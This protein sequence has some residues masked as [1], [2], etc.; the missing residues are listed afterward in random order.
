MAN[1]VVV[2]L[3]ESEISCSICL[4]LFIDPR[5]LPCMHSFCCKCLTE[6][7]KKSEP[8]PIYI[9]PLCRTEYPTRSFD[10][11]NI[12]V[13]YFLTDII[14]RVNR[15]DVTAS[16][17]SVICSTDDCVHPSV[18]YCT[19]GCDNLCADCMRHHSKSKGTRSHIVLDLERMTSMG[20]I[21]LGEVTPAYCKAHPNYIIDQYCVDCDLAACDTCLLR[22]HRKHNLVDIKRQVEK[23]KKQLENIIQQTSSIIEIIDQEIEDSERNDKKSISDIKNTKKQINK[24]IDGIIE[25]LNQRRKQIFKDLNKI[26]QQKEKAVMTVYNDQ[27][28]NKTAVASLRSYTKNVLHHGRDYDRVQQV[29]GLQSRMESMN[30]TMITSFTWS[31][32]D[33]RQTLSQDEM[34]VATISA[35]TDNL[36]ARDAKTCGMGEETMARSLNDNVVAKISMRT[37]DIVTGLVVMDQTVLVVHYNKS[38]IQA[39][40]LKSPH[41]SQTVSVK[42]LANPRDVVRFPPGRPQLVISDSANGKLVWI[43][44]EQH[45]DVWEITSQRSLKVNY[46]PCGLGIRDNQLLVCDD[47]G[48]I[49]AISTSRVETGSIDMRKKGIR[50]WKAV[51]QLT[52]P[53]FIIKDYDNQVVLVDEKGKLQRIYCGQQGFKYG[54]IVC[55]GHSIYVTDYNNSRVDELDDKGH[56]VKQLIS[57]QIVKWPHRLCVDEQGRVYVAQG[58]EGKEEVWVIQT[59]TSTDKHIASR[60]DRLQT[61][62]VIM[63]LNVTWWD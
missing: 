52:S 5:I 17:G 40:P 22:K 12:K 48:V 10:L 8:N 32:H 47:D 57:Q 38:T 4:Q 62:K 37:Q 50:P 36:E 20:G 54:D 23:S 44:L 35:K 63:K 15:Q 24:V 19:Q 33:H 51:A 14:R 11:E 34:R 31:R 58:K 53:G 16:H 21:S 42:E 9:C 26:E 46:S 59:A 25:K 41:Q 18:Q 55:H 6:W 43:K 61:R 56:H 60:A 49:H 2:D 39:Y 29:R 1:K 30:T 3:C 27:Q 13:N 28:L 7:V 45:N